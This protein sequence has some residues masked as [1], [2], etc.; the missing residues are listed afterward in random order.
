MFFLLFVLARAAYF[1]YFYKYFHFFYFTVFNLN[2][3][4]K[5][6]NRYHRLT[7][8]ALQKYLCSFESDAKIKK[9]ERASTR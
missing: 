4:S 5:V 6:Q 8:L 7:K 9:K 3:S 2:E 1:N